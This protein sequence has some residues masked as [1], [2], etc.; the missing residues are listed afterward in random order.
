MTAPAD[1]AAPDVLGAD[2]LVEVAA[3]V[4]VLPDLHRTPHVPNIGI[5]VG[6]RATLVVESGMGIANGERVLAIARELG[7]ERPIYITATRF[8]PSTATACRHDSSL[9]T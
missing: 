7:G 8:T 2:A 4:W 1:E 9:R 5:L 3:G 6:E